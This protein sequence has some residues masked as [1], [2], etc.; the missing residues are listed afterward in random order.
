MDTIFDYGIFTIDY[1]SPD[2]HVSVYIIKDYDGN[3]LCEL[4]YDTHNEEHH[5]FRA[6]LGNAYKQEVK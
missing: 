2:P 5:K 3:V 4:T 6:S 1:Y